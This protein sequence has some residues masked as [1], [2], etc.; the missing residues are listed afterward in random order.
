MKLSEALEAVVS[1]R[2]KEEKKVIGISID[3]I[4]ISMEQLNSYR[5]GL[6][7]EDKKL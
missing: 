6:Y 5:W 3:D 1:L 4:R 7:I 2:S